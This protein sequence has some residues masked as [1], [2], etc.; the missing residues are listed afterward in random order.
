MPTFRDRPLRRLNKAA[1]RCKCSSRL[2]VLA[3]HRGALIGVLEYA[4]NLRVTG[5]A[6]VKS[7]ES[8]GHLAGQQALGR[9]DLSTS[10]PVCASV[11]PGYAASGEA[12]E[13]RHDLSRR[14]ETSS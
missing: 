2:C 3:L 11:L 7:A 13:R 4:A 5:A 10:P 12:K 6:G 14:S 8:E 9:A 1:S